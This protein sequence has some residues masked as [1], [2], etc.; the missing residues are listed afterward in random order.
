MSALIAPACRDV[1]VEAFGALTAIARPGGQGR[2]YRPAAIPPGLGP[3]PVV[4]KLYHRAPPLGAAAAL[5]EMVAWAAS[6]AP[7]RRARLH[8]VTAWP[9]ATVS[10]HGGLVGVAMPDVSRRFSVPFLMPSGRA[11]PVLLALEHLLGGDWYL[12]RRGLAVHLDSAMRA[13]VAARVAGALAFLHQRAI[14]VGDL[15]PSNLLVGFGERPAVC[16]IDC[17]SMA[18]RGRRALPSVQT[19][20]WELP[21][22]YAEP[23]ATYAADGYKLGL[24]VLRLFARSHQAR[25]LAPHAE[26]VPSPLRALLRRALGPDGANRPSAGEWERALIDVLTAGDGLSERYPG[27]P[28]RPP[29]VPAL[30]PRPRAPASPPA[31]QRAPRP[32]SPALWIALVLVFVLLLTRL[33]AEL[34][35]HQDFAPRNG[36]TQ[37]Y[38]VIPQGGGPP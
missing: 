30:R 18:F 27:P 16:F 36:G 34:P 35:A 15:A 8:R 14:V 24:V 23:P 9:L 21:R 6:L 38:Y 11:Q 1:P 5:A 7:Q 4:V 3:G 2:V 20:D 32:M 19:G 25:A 29:P 31:L 22:G 12:E 37:Y 28:S 26:H 17:D 13:R 33:L 10:L